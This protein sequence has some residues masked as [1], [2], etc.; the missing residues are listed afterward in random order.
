M[1]QWFLV[2][3]TRKPGIY[4]GS[5]FLHFFFTSPTGLVSLHL[6]GLHHEILS[7]LLHMADLIWAFAGFCGLFPP[8]FSRFGTKSCQWALA[9]LAPPTL[10]SFRWRM[11]SWVQNSLSACVIYQ[12]KKNK[13]YLA[14]VR[15]KWS[16]HLHMDRVLI[17]GI[18]LIQCQL[19]KLLY[20]IGG[21]T[22]VKGS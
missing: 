21:E 3:S 15:A 6:H 10:I 11:R 13:K 16:L 1:Q 7:L 19:S 12:S 22:K 9:Q 8:F 2:Q 17:E 14:H 4:M 20:Q 5:S 18:N